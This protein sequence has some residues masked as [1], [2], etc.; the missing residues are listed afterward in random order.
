[1][2]EQVFDQVKRK[3]LAPAYD[4][5]YRLPVLSDLWANLRNVKSSVAGDA[6]S[7]AW[8]A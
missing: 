5:C 6:A 8:R 4:D 3:R 7:E 2:I 1:M